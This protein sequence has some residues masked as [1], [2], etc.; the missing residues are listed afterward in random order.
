MSPAAH[1][2]LSTTP[3]ACG[4]VLLAAGASSRMGAPKALLVHSDGRTFLRAACESLH[5]AGAAPLVVVLGHQRELI[6]EELHRVSS[7][8]PAGALELAI[9]PA[10]ERGQLS[11][12]CTGLAALSDRVPSALLALVDQPSLPREVLA[13]LLDAAAREPGALHV[14]LFAGARGHP[15]IFPTALLAGLRAAREGESAREVIARLAVPVREHAVESASVLLDLDTPEELA[16]W[17]ARQEET[18]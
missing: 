9:N 1:A 18:R 6:E 7:S 15:A 4:A 11:S 17:R 8:L 5:A 12:I 16:A 10:P 3:A 13:R 2:P 14:P